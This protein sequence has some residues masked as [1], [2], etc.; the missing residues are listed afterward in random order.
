MKTI[1][2]ILDAPVIYKPEFAY[3]DTVNESYHGVNCNIVT[4]SDIAEAVN[5]AAGIDS[6]IDRD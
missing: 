4:N 5:T 1:K 2:Q 6:Y 3:L